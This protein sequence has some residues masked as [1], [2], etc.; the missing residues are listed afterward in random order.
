MRRALAL[1]VATAIILLVAAG[2]MARPGSP[3]RQAW[4]HW[5]AIRETERAAG[6]RWD[7][8]AVLAIP[9]YGDAHALPDVIEFA[10][11]E[12]PFCRAL[13]P[14]IDSAVRAGVRVGILQLP[15]PIHASARSAA[16]IA[17]CSQ[18]QGRFPE[19]HRSLMTNAEWRAA[20]SVEGL[21][22]A[23]DSASA[24]VLSVCAQSAEVAA[25]LEQ[26]LA[27]ASELHVPG[28]P[29][30]LTRRGVVSGRATAGALEA[31]AAH[32]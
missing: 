11:Y 20:G 26:H 21:A 8:L 2:L 7:S 1:D 16:L 15:L 24:N 12:C 28:T 4:H 19:V 5:L 30:L 27:M 14:V 23:V 31:V 13:S 6:I 10:D 22:R 17:M 18:A 3:L 32:R 25:I 29:L 9:L